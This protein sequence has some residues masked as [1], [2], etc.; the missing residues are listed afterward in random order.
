[1]RF[2]SLASARRHLQASP[3]GGCADQHRGPVG[4]VLSEHSPGHA[5]QL[6]RYGYCGHVTVDAG[7]ELGQPHTQTGGLFRALLQDGT[8]RLHQESSQV[9]VPP[10][11]NPQQLLLAAS[12]VFARDDSQPRGKPSPLFESGSIAIAAMMAVVVTGPMPGIATSRRQASFSP[13]I[14]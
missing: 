4:F 3:G 10:F 12:G 9:R 1:M 6:I 8:G 7:C 13:A 5:G 14:F 2:P 11:A